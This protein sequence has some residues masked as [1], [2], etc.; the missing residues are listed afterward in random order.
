MEEEREEEGE[1]LW[2]AVVT[3][4]GAMEMSG[5]DEIESDVFGGENYITRG[6]GRGGGG[7]EGEL[8]LEVKTD[9]LLAKQV[10]GKETEKVH[11]ELRSREFGH[12]RRELTC[13]PCGYTVTVALA[14]GRDTHAQQR[15]HHGQQV[16][17]RRRR[18]KLPLT[19]TAVEEVHSQIDHNQNVSPLGGDRE[20]PLDQ[21][22]RGWR[23][24]IMVT[25][26][27]SCQQGH[28]VEDD[29]VGRVRV[30]RRR[31]RRRRGQGRFRSGREKL[32]AAVFH[33]FPQLVGLLRGAPHAGSAAGID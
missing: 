3:T 5:R 22:N 27:I 33:H 4:R 16:R 10:G 18:R 17:K 21:R 28:Q 15:G 25:G 2:R 6:R 12:P 19:A 14:R 31:K 7:R 32:S 11:F 1:T 8:C 29:D 30:A 9:R 23:A 24:G 20:H 26:H 13:K